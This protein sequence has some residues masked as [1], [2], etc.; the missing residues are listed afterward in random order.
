MD[1]QEIVAQ[2]IGVRPSQCL[3]LTG[4][5]ESTGTRCRFADRDDLVVLVSPDW[6]TKEELD[7]AHAVCRHAARSVHEAIAPLS[8]GGQTTFDAGSGR[9]AAIFPYVDGTPLDPAVPAQQRDAARVLAQL[10]RSLLDWA[11][12]PRPPHGCDVPLH[13]MIG[14]DGEAALQAACD[15]A[16]IHDQELDEWWEGASSRDYVRCPTKGDFW[17]ANLLTSNDRVVGAIDWHDAEILRCISE[18]AWAASCCTGSGA[19][20]GREFFAFIDVYREHGGPVTDR[21]LEDVVMFLRL[22]RRDLIRRTVALGVP[23]EHFYAQNLVRIFRETTVVSSI[24]DRS[25]PALTGCRR[26]GIPCP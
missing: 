11:G 10:H 26:D 19:E 23:I 13:K 8:I 1:I 3:P 12:G 21:D 2:V 15:P 4:G 22:R 18:L 5:Q 17:A 24:I 20:V 7:W 9:H 16:Q 6:R 14:A 25:S